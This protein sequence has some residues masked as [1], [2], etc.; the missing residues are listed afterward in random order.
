MKGTCIEDLTPIAE[1]LKRMV[2]ESRLAPSE[3]AKAIGISERSLYRYLQDPGQM[4]LW[5][6]KNITYV[7]GDTK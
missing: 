7:I 2:K 6:Y 4:K 3:I 5:T 1:E